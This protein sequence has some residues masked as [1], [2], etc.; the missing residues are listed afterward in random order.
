MRESGLVLSLEKILYQL[1]QKLDGD[2]KH[3]VRV[4]SL[5]LHLWLLVCVI[6]RLP[7]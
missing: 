5:F 2:A 3:N 1:V 4:I 7:C 6:A